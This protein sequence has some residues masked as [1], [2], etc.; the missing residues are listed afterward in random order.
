M[1]L[2]EG[3]M[4]KTHTIFPTEPYNT[5]ELFSDGGNVTAKDIKIYPIK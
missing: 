2:D 4:V 5:I 1:F 3:A